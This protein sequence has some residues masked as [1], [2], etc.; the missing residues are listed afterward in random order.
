MTVFYA[1]GICSIIFAVIAGILLNIA[2]GDYKAISSKV[3]QV[4]TLKKVSISRQN[5]IDGFEEEITQ[6]SN[7]L[8]HVQNLNSRLIVLAGLD[9]ER[10]E[11]NLGLG[12]SEEGNPEAETS[13]Q[14]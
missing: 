10:G 4:E 11:Q 12:G 1:V 13:D 2:W 14:Q 7:S 9:P 5:A 3:A 6:L 8:A